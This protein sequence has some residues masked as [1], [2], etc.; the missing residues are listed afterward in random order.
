MTAVAAADRDAVFLAEIRRVADEVAA[1]HA[2]DVDREGR[3]PAEA[4]AA[5]REQRALSAFVPTELGGDGV[6]RAEWRSG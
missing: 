4:I 1:V 6:S 5:L 3:F 2:T